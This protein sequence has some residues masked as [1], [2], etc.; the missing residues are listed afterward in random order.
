MTRLLLCFVPTD[1]HGHVIP[2]VDAA[3]RRIFLGY[4]AALVLGIAA[5]FMW[6]WWWLRERPGASASR[7]AG[8]R[9]ANFRDVATALSVY[10]LAIF[11]P[12]FAHTTIVWFAPYVFAGSCL[13]LLPILFRR[14]SNPNP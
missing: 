10:P 7:A 14:R 9:A 3:L 4:A 12:E 2:G 11:I 1:G 6:F 8:N 5:V 13:F